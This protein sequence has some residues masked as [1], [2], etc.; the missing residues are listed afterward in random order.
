MRTALKF[1]T[2]G[3]LA[4]LLLAPRKGDETRDLLIDRGREYVKELISSG[5][6]AAAD[7]G[8]EASNMAHEYRSEGR[9]YDDTVPP[10]VQ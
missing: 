9:S 2:L 7:L 4:G 10:S 5:Q 3:L 1:F 6:Q 8:K